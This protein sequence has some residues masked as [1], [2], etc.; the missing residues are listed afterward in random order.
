MDEG[1]TRNY[2]NC[3]WFEDLFWTEPCAIVDSFMAA[4]GLFPRYR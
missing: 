3:N 1:M 4:A 2:A